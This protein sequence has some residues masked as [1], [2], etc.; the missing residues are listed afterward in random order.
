MS[1]T[2]AELVG[3]LGMD[4]AEFNRG[5]DGS[6]GKFGK[7][8]PAAVAATALVAAA[9]AAAGLAALHF[10]EQFDDSFDS[11]RISTGKTGKALAGLEDDFKAVVASVPTDFASASTAI[12]DINKRLGLTGPPLQELSKQFVT[13]SRLTKTDVAE[14]VRL[15]TRLFGDWSIATKDQSGALDQIFRASQQSGIGVSDL[16]DTVV[17]FGAPL[18]NMGFGFSDSVAMMAKWEKEGV[19]TS[20]VLTGMKFALKTF[21][22]AGEDPQ[23]ALGAIIPK[24]RDMKNEQ[25]AMN[26]GMATFGLRAGP[27]MV[28]AIREGRFE[29]ADFAK[30]IENGT[31]TIMKAAR[32]TDGWRESLT[33]LKNKALVALEPALS[34]MLGGIDDAV[35]GMG[36]A[37]S[38][39]KAKSIFSNIGDAAGVVKDKIGEAFTAI[40]PIVGPVLADIGKTIKVLIARWTPVFEA[41]F[42]AI[43][44][45]VKWAWPTIKATIMS[46]LNVIAGIIK[47]AMAL[48]RGDWSSA[49]KAIKQIV[50]GAVS[51]IQAL[52]RGLGRAS[53][54]ILKAAWGALKSIAS[55]AWNAMA[56]AVRSGI[57]RNI[58]IVSSLPGRILSALSSLGGLLVSAGADLLNGLWSGISGALGGLLSKIQNVASQIGSAFKKAMH[59]D[60]P[61]KL[62]AGFGDYMM[63]GLAL[64]VVDN[65]N[66][67][68]RA[69]SQVADALAA[70][71]MPV[72]T[73]TLRPA[74]YGMG[75]SGSGTGI[76]EVHEHYHTHIPAGSVLVGT[77]DQAAKVL[78]PHVTKHQKKN[79]N[80]KGRGR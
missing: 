28:A 7:F 44:Q 37:L 63:Q 53:L 79:D 51:G 78:S 54:A 18:R 69:M 56:G 59:I 48:I 11:M 6:L 9:F 21:A 76:S 8:G 23:K 36:K 32:D 39:D 49:W 66:K 61:S 55:S 72:P 65:V 33:V 15:G 27:D 19:N 30:Q 68:L 60:S 67:P 62:F 14:N 74:A 10:A 58:S 80:R 52:I 77:L 22:K 73:A 70:Q 12:A 24:I 45:V 71:A 17:S 57:S 42:R 41:V 47:L 16:M 40:A 3:K 31:D 38:S 75:L 26:L 20:T 1:L 34:A 5:I 25:E 2:V 29:Y 50:N 35:S 64:G 4:D 43:V 13:F 46:A